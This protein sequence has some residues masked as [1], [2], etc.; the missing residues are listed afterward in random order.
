MSRSGALN[1]ALPICLMEKVEH[2]RFE[3]D[4][5]G[6]AAQLTALD[7]ENVITKPETTRAPPA[8]PSGRLLRKRQ[9]HLKG[10]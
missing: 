7:I 8:G 6:P 1:T 10:K 5:L 3:C 4:G 9:A 2:L